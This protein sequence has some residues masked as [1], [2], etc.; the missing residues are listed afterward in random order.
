MP[1][2]VILFLIRG[3]PEMLHPFR[4]LMGSYHMLT[5]ISFL[6]AVFGMLVVCHDTSQLAFYLRANRD[7]HRGLYDVMLH[8]ACGKGRMVESSL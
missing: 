3:N 8:V 1:N 7:G 4:L 5:G 2:I 6:N